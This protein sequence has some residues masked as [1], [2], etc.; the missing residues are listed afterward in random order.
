MPPKQIERQSMSFIM[1]GIMVGMM[2]GMM[3]S[4]TAKITST[5]RLRARWPENAS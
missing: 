3:V 5:E 1:V 4:I 2:V